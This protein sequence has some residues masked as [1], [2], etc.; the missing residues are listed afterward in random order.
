MKWKKNG[1]SI[2]INE[3]GNTIVK[4]RFASQYF[5][6]CYQHGYRDYADYE[7]KVSLSEAK[8]HFNT[9]RQ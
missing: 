4:Y 2:W 1:S 7:S 5:Y 8:Q 3:L 6:L 9:L